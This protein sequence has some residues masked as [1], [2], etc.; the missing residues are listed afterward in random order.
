MTES[1]LGKPFRISSHGERQRL[2]IAGLSKEDFLKAYASDPFF[3]ARV[4]V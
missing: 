3:R 1:T 4:Q 2:E